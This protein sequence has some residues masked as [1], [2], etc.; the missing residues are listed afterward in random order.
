M[1]TPIDAASFAGEDDAIG[2][3][4]KTGWTRVFPHPLAGGPGTPDERFPELWKCSPFADAYLGA[5]AAAQVRA[6]A[7]GRR[8]TVDLLAVGFSG[9]DCVGHD[10]GPDSAEVHDTILRLDRTLGTLFEAL[11]AAV[12]R[13]RYVVALSAD[14]GVSAIPEQRQQAGADAG[15]VLAADIR[16]TAESAL[17]AAHGPG[18]HVAAVIAPSVYLTAGTREREQQS[19]GPARPA[20]DAIAKWPGVL[21]VIAGRTLAGGVRRRD[22]L[23]R[24]AALSYHPAESG[25]FLYLL[26]PGWIHGGDSAASHGSPHAYDRRVPLLFMGAPIKPGRH[27][28][29]ASPADIA[30]TLASTIGLKLTGVDGAVLHAALR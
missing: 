4:P 9:L 28:G 3:R 11:D 26:Q 10:F 1:W 20:I 21:R 7:L 18:P 2:E 13:E 27:A 25:D 12:G 8:G 6:F 16:R 30:P 22:P 24:A 29:T 5:M 17:V 15:R 19:P 14:H 23:E